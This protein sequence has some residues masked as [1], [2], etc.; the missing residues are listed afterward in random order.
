[1]GIKNG[2]KKRRN[3]FNNVKIV[4]NNKKTIGGGNNKP[5][6]KLS[7]L[8]YGG[9]SRGRRNRKKEV[10]TALKDYIREKYIYIYIIYEYMYAYNNI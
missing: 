6:V 3:R 7:G 9:K 1:M 8:S 4:A 5:L 2:K 10:A